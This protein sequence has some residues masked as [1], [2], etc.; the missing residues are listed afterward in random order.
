MKPC[1]YLE[2]MLSQR[3]SPPLCQGRLSQ[4]LLVSLGCEGSLMDKCFHRHLSRYKA[5][6]KGLA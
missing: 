3:K 4:Q 5:A 2:L 1:G 6:F